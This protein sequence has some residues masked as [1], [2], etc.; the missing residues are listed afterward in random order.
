[1]LVATR[2]V[3]SIGKV[4]WEFAN[5]A[6]LK[7]RALEQKSW[8]EFQ[9]VFYSHYVPTTIKVKKKIEFLSLGS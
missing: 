3:Q 1:M 7:S 2:V 5:T 4:W 9:D 8:V 6:F